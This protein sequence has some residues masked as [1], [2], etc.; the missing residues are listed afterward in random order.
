MGGVEVLPQLDMTPSGYQNPSMNMSYTHNMPP[1]QPPGHRMG[2]GRMGIGSEHRQRGFRH[3]PYKSLRGRVRGPK[4]HLN[5]SPMAASQS[6]SESIVKMPVSDIS[7]EMKV[8]KTEPEIQILDNESSNQSHSDTG[9]INNSQNPSHSQQPLLQ[10]AESGVDLIPGENPPPVSDSL[11]MNPN[12]PPELAEGQALHADL[13]SLVSDQANVSVDDLN[14]SAISDSSVNVKMEGGGDSDTE[15]EI[16]GMEPGVDIMPQDNWGQNISMSDVSMDAS[17]DA[18]GATGSS[19]DLSAGQS[20]Y[21]KYFDTFTFSMRQ[22]HLWF[23]VTM[24]W[25]L[26]KDVGTHI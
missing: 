13:A 7:N 5:R 15:L 26:H 4:Q 16:T 23:H 22:N 6:H 19:L 18:L 12:I 17:Y 3:D 11:S 10:S 24:T 20:G 1:Q 21:S 9:A 14:S 8:I 2:V 25:K